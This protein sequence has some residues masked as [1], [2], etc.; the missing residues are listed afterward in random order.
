MLPVVEGESSH[1]FAIPA[2]PRLCELQ[3][4]VTLG[5]FHWYEKKKTKKYAISW[6]KMEYL[7]TY[8]SFLVLT[9]MAKKSVTSLLL[10][11]HFTEEQVD[12]DR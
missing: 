7:K 12:V 8:S 11:F 10:I 1:H 5:P 6:K 4:T 3:E 2:N 9:E